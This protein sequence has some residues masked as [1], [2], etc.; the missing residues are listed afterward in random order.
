MFVAA[1]ITAGLLV[2]VGVG[3]EETPEE[4]IARITQEFAASIIKE[5]PESC[6][7]DQGIGWTGYDRVFEIVV[8]DEDYLNNA[9]LSTGE[10]QAVSA[11]FMREL[12][13]QCEARGR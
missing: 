10:R 6:T 5:S 3:D 11:R 7:A 9:G 8:F 4:R 1:G 2:L 13:K 12:R